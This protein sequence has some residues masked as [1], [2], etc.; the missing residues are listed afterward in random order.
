MASR[1]RFIHVNV[2]LVSLALV[3]CAITI[4]RRVALAIDGVVIHR[5]AVLLVN[6]VL[7]LTF[8]FVC[9]AS[10]K[11]PERSPRAYFAS[12]MYGSFQ[13]FPICLLYLLANLISYTALRRIPA[14]VFAAISQLKV[15]TTAFFAVVILGS[16]ISLRRWRTLAALTLA[17]M[18]VTLSNQPQR[19]ENLELPTGRSAQSDQIEYFWGVAFAFMQTCFTG[20]ACIILEFRLKQVDSSNNTMHDIW[21]RNLQLSACSIMI[22]FPLALMETSWSIMRDWSLAASLISVLHAVGGILVALSIMHASSI[23][24]TVAVCAGL[25]LTSLLGGTFGDSPP[26]TNALLACAIVA[27]MIFGY[28]DD[29]ELER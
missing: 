17:V 24:K 4:A 13:L 11:N 21:D 14:S 16:K 6:E 23:S 8:S 3:D 18:I 15:L 9:V 25:T 26:N 5:S 12:F 2:I 10:K 1:T 28:R 20:L 19:A 22:Y 27:V 29:I 7:K